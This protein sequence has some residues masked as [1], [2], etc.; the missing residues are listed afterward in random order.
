M[1]EEHVARRGPGHI[2]S[3]NVEQWHLWQRPSR[4]SLNHHSGKVQP[5][6]RNASR[7]R[8]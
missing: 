7:I 1:D 4:P 3:D 2:R 8:L 6:E 5:A